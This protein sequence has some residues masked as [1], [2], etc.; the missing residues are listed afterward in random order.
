ML[1]FSFLITVYNGERFLNRVIDS[2][3]Y[4]DIPQSEYEILCLDDCSQDH[5]VKIIEQYRKLHSNVRLIQNKVNSRLGTNVNTIIASARGKYLWPM[6]QDDYIEPNCLLRLY[7]L[8]EC[9]KLDLLIFNYRR[10]FENEEM[11]SE[12]KVVTNSD[13]LSGVDW[14]KHQFA[15]RDYCLYLLGYSWR[16]VYR[17]ELFKT[18]N[19]R[20]VEGM[21]YDDTVFLLKAIVYAKRMQSI[22]DVLYNY[23]INESSFTY[24]KDFVK[25]GDLI[26]EFAFMVGQEVEDFY[27]E[28]THIDD[29][30]ASNLFAHLLKRYNN[31][32]FDIIRTSNEQKKA[33]Y[34]KLRENKSFVQSKRHYLNWKAK[35]LTSIIGYPV[36]WMCYY[37]YKLYK[38][39]KRERKM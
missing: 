14:I 2:L 4:Q 11:Q 15:D 37:A 24:R 19:I 21:N 10:V 9:G 31:F 3:L 5:S 6:G 28:L 1:K 32:V 12:C 8:L 18:N 38:S 22:D 27:N 33:F 36:A 39:I 26:Y 25:R 34:R 7:T 29:S 30:L 16:A 20:C 17:N 35:L 13:T 23:R